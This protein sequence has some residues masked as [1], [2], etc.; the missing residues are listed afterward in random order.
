M[1]R[2]GTNRQCTGIYG[3]SGD[4]IIIYVQADDDD[5]LPSIRFS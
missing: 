2:G 5:P 1:S 3:Y 4:D